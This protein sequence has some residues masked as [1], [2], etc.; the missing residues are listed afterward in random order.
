MIKHFIS[1]LIFV[2]IFLFIYFVISFYVSNNNK[3]KISFNRE[4]TQ[5][6]LEK[7]FLNLP[8]LLNDTDDVIEFNSG[9]KENKN[10]IKRNFWNLFKKDD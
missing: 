10:K 7:Q 3:I 2:F 9:Y 6:N 4:N 5:K 8:I 1:V